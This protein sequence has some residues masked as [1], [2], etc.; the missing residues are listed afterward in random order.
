M[1]TC[2]A[3]QSGSRQNWQNG[4]AAVRTWK[5]SC[6]RSKSK[7]CSLSMTWKPG[8]PPSRSVSMAVQ[9]FLHHS[10][11]CSGP[12]CS[13]LPGECSCLH[14]Y[15]CFGV[16]IYSAQMAWFQKTQN[17]MY[18]AQ[19]QVLCSNTSCS[20]LSS[21][22]SPCVL[23]QCCYFPTG[24]ASTA[25]LCSAQLLPTPEEHVTC[26]SAPE[27]V[28]CIQAET[29]LACCAQSFVLSYCL[30]TCGLQLAHSCC[31]QVYRSC[32][33][34]PSPQTPVHIS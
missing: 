5:L 2:P 23:C 13:R 4:K 8:L 18:E 30:Y 20:Q 3:A 1:R 26:T 31:R 24:V 15:G 34:T 10:N 14:N 7:A 25:L 9:C 6:R 29:R 16:S 22:A 32:S 11:N 33:Y 19:E 27:F 12:A 21:G 17:G 28:V